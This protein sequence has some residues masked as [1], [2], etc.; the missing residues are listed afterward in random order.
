MAGKVFRIGHMG[1]L[2]DPM[3]LGALSGVEATL[4][5]LK[6]PYESGL[7]DAIGYLSDTA[8]E[9]E[10]QPDTRRVV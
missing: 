3:I 8:L 5:R 2:N 4:R 1:D 9:P 7:A 6:I 10:R